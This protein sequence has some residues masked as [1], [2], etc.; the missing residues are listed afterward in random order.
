MLHLQNYLS[1]SQ[2]REILHHC[3]EIGKRAPL[4]I[5]TMKNRSPFNYQMTNCGKVGWISDQNGYQYIENHPVTN[6]PW[7]P[8]P[9]V[10]RNLTKSLAAKV[11]DYNFTPETCLINYYQKENSKLGIHQDNTE[12]N[13]AAPIISISLGDDG[14]FLIGGKRRKDP[15]KEIILKSGDILILHDESRMFYHG[16]KGIVPGTSNLLNSGGRLNLTIR[17]VY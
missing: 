9:E 16:I 15:T 17:Q 12:I 4:F 6:K 14:I 8:I 3:R 7:Q 13:K 1:E 11:G 5:P 10:I 2:Q